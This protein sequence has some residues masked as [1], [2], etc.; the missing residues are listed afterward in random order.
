MLWVPLADK[1]NDP[2]RG[3]DPD[4][5]PTVT[6]EALSVHERFVTTDA[7]VAETFTVSVVL[8]AL[9][10]PVCPAGTAGVV[11]VTVGAV[12]STAPIVKVTLASSLLMG[13]VRFAFLN[14]CT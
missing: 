11:T 6:G 1:L 10:N 5:P 3:E 14:A 2:V 4:W 9:K 13:L 12:V 8:A 7:S